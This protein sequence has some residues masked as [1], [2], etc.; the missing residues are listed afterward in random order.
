MTPLPRVCI[1]TETYYPVVGGGETQ[2][3]MLAEGLVAHGLAAMVLTRRSDAS[4]K[5]IEQYG[6]VTV[7]R[8]PPTGH[9]HL[10]KWG[11]LLTG[12]PALIRLRRQYDL[13][14]V[15]GF[16]V[17]GIPAVLVS[18]LLGKGC[19]LKADSQGEMSGAFF[20]GGL[21]KLRLTP[22]SLPVRMFLAVRN[23][24]LRH[25]GVFV[26]IC[27]DLAS[28]LAV[29]GVNSAAIRLVPNSVDTQKFRPVNRREKQMLRTKL[30]LP[31]DD[32]II[33]YTGRLVSYKGLPLLLDVWTELNRERKDSTLVLL[34]SGGLDMHNCE[35]EL[36]AYVSEHGLRDSV[37][38]AGDVPNVHEYLQASDIFVFPTE[39]DAFPLALVEAMACGLPVVSTPV[40]GIKDIITHMHDGLLVPPAERRQTYDALTTLMAE[41]ALAAR[42]GEAARQTVQE[43]YSA[44]KVT[45][46]YVAL[47]TEVMNSAR[48]SPSRAN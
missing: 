28:E 21:A 3:R 42:L 18:K 32:T 25:A 24:I 5:K 36:K 15:S 41:P 8:L 11:L 38:F 17:L 35:A 47:F 34:G 37:H 7:Y 16:R 6:P 33:T 22:A 48:K 9:Q 30:A 2:A 46:K 40:G 4:L 31:Q 1:F 14:F 39:S 26:A 45:Q 23:M 12:F 13:V 44:A 29:N 43:R 27:T 20:A 10:K 19:V